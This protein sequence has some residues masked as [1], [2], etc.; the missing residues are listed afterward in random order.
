MIHPEDRPGVLDQ[1]SAA[2]RARDEFHA[3]YRILGGG[4]EYRWFKIHAKPV[5]AADGNVTNWSGVCANIH[6]QRVLEQELARRTEELAQSS[7]DFQ[8]FAYRIGHDLKEPL[9]MIAMYSELLVQRDAGNVS[10]ESRTFIQY[11]QDGVSRIE[12]QLRDLLEYAR[13]GSLEIKRELIDFNT[14]VESA[15]A[16]LSPAILE[17]GAHVAHGK[18]PRLVANADR[19]RSVFQNLIGNALKYRGIDPPQIHISARLEG[20]DWIFSVQD[21]GTGFQAEDQERIFKPFERASSDSKIQGSGLGLAIVK[22]IVEKKGGRI[23]AESTVG[24]GSTFHFTLPRTMEKF[25]PA[26]AR[27]CDPT[28]SSDARAS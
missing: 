19:V 15:V 20:D 2:I 18:L 10:A 17:T 9:R 8:R 27:T 14:V 4:G 13:V 24:K 1:W 5:T 22:R 26:Q 21:N 3:T 23:W 6:E 28:L 12:S 7:E 25:G 16:N 11:I